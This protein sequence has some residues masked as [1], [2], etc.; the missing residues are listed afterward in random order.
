MH[1]RTSLLLAVAFFAGCQTYGPYEV[2]AAR[3]MDIEQVG[4]VTL[5]A[6]IQLVKVDGAYTC[7]DRAVQASSNGL[8]ACLD[9]DRPSYASATYHFSPGAHRI[10]V[11]YNRQDLIK[12]GPLSGLQ[13]LTVDINPGKK[14]VVKYD[15]EE[16]SRKTYETVSGGEDVKLIMIQQT[17]KYWVETVGD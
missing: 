7:Y 16:V 9:P 10:W 6:N 11:A 1:Y 5:P 15:I 14:Y 8:S 3:G 12:S 4:I 17:I 13:A 2:D